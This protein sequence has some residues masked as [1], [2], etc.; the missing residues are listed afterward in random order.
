M[1][2]CY[3]CKTY[4]GLGLFSAW[5]NLDKHSFCHSC[6][7]KYAEE[8]R[9]RVLA[10]VMEGRPPVELFRI[11]RVRTRNPDRPGSRELLLGL[12]S[13][14]DKGVC[15]LELGLHIKADPGWGWAFG[16]LGAIIADS[17]AKER[18]RGSFQRQ[19]Q[20]GAKEFQR[21]LE[22]AEDVLFYPRDEIQQLKFK[23]GLF[24]IRMGKSRKRFAYED[25]RRLFKEFRDVAEAYCD[26]LDRGID[27]VLACRQASLEEFGR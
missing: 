6:A 13:F 21:I 26:A 11:P 4:L 24:E 5:R 17:A 20:Q 23:A 12:A 9:H 10:E 22:E 25:G 16:L 7:V 8:R 19:E 2:R 14:T 1:A 3:S 27:P 15:F 18:L